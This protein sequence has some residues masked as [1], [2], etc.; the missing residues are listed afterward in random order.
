MDEIISNQ[1]NL[2]PE[3]DGFANWPNW[4]KEEWRQ[5]PNPNS[6]PNLNSVPQVAEVVK[7]PIGPKDSIRK[8][9][10]TFDRVA[11]TGFAAEIIPISE[12]E[13]EPQSQ[14]ESPKQEKFF[15]D[16]TMLTPEVK[17]GDTVWEL[18]S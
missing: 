17:R 2:A 13:P 7:E 6:D 11:R 16:P 10:G 5:N 4:K 8:R 3:P 14:P 15:V 1:Q 18:L 9:L 12:P